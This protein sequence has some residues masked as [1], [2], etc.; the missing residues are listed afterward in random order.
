MKRTAIIS[1]FALTLLLMFS[2]CLRLGMGVQGSGTRKTEKRDLKPFKSIETS[3]AY[4]VDV[5]CQKPAAFEIEGDDNI[6]PLI[7]T[8]VRDGTLYVS[9]EKNYTTDRPVSLRITLPDLAGVSTQ[10]A[11][12]VRIAEVKNDRLELHSSG[13]AEIN[14]SGQS[15]F[16]EVGSTGAGKI[17]AGNLRAEKVLVSVT[18]AADVDVYATEQLDATVSGAGQVSYGGDP[19]VVNKNVSGVG[20]LSKKG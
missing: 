9:N 16:V 5:T 17:D 6:L 14:A 20:S 3:G 19:K 1:I 2:G 10:G 12:K 7:K 8:E 4:D 15:R 18:G 13:A 11:G